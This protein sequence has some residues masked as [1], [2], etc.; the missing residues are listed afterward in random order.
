MKPA[1]M[2]M[3]VGVIG[4][5]VAAVAATPTSSGDVATVAAAAAL[6]MPLPDAKMRSLLAGRRLGVAG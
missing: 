5:G 3:V 2:A 4:L 1:W 6:S